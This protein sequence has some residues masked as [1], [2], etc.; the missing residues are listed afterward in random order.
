MSLIAMLEKAFPL[1]E[2]AASK[3]PTIA[4]AFSIAKAIAGPKEDWNKNKGAASGKLIEHLNRSGHR[5]EEAISH[6]RQGSKLRGFMDMA[7]PGFAEE[8]A[9]EVSRIAREQ[10][11]APIINTTATHG[12]GYRILPLNQ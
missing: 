1:I 8:A 6:L 11:S 7:A 3:N 9:K 4:Q 2:I 5:A 10:G 12:A